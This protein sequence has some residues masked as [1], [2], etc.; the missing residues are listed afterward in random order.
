[1]RKTVIISV[2]AILVG[3]LGATPAQDLSLQHPPRLTV[4]DLDALTDARIAIVKKTLQL[5]PEQEKY[6]PAIEDAIRSRAKS[7]QT[8]LAH[9]RNL[10][11]AVQSKSFVTGTQLNFRTD[12]PTGW[13]SVL[14]T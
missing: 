7:R 14:Q 13:R 9:S 10:A 6:W 1:M 4:K 11:I 3:A 12:A 5:T 8:R 2:I